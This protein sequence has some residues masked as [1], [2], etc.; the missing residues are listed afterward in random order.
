[1]ENKKDAKLKRWNE[2]NTITINTQ[3]ASIYINNANLTLS[4]WD[5]SLLLGEIQGEQDGNL[6]V[7]PKVKITMSLQFVKALQDLFNKNIAIFER[8]V[9]PIQEIQAEAEKP[10][11]T[12]NEE[13]VPLITSGEILGK[14]K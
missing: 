14:K 12:K 2:D 7:L 10:L 13:D 11:E 3:V 8:D 6:V 4:N 9:S 1:M 5:A